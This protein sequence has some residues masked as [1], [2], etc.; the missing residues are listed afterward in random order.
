MHPTPPAA[1]LRP[2]HRLNAAIRALLHRA[3]GRL[4]AE[5]R[6]EYDALVEAYVAAVQDEEQPVL[7]A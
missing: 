5:E 6:R 4:S 2:A 7:A 3:G 1:E